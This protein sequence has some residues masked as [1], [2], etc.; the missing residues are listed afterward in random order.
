MGRDW[1]GCSGRELHCSAALAP[2]PPPTSSLS[3]S[4]TYPTNL[5]LC[6]CYKRNAWKSCCQKQ[7][8]TRTGAALDVR[9]KHPQTPLPR[10]CTRDQATPAGTQMYGLKAF[11]LTATSISRDSFL[12]Q[13]PGGHAWCFL[14]PVLFL[15]QSFIHPTNKQLSY[16]NCEG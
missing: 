15:P 11:N 5:P 10:G 9:T 2:I 13:R 6:W 7:L 1:I 12:R 16:I 8:Q 14:C 4:Q 3:S